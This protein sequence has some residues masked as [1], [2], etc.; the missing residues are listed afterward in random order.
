MKARLGVPAFAMLRPRAGD[1][2]YS[3]EEVA[4]M[5]R[6]VANLLPWVDGFVFGILTK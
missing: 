5:E 4:V 1:F 2:C 3:A 6:D